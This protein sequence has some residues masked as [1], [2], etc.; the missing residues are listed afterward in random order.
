M[1]SRKRDASAIWMSVSVLAVMF[2]LAGAGAAQA[3]QCPAYDPA[4]PIVKCTGANTWC[5]GT[6]VASEPVCPND[7]KNQ[8]TKVDCGGCTCTCPDSF[9]MNCLGTNGYCQKTN[10]ACAPLNR[11]S[12]CNSDPGAPGYPDVTLNKCGSCLSGFTE[13]FGN[14]VSSTNPSC[15]PP[16]IWDPCN[17]KCIEKYV[18]SNPTPAQAPQ[19]VDIK[20][21]GNASI[22]TGDLFFSPGKAIRVDG[23][24]ATQL[25]IG[26]WGGGATSGNVRI[27]GSL[28]TDAGVSTVD[29]TPV[30]PKTVKTDSLCLTNGTICK[31]EW[32]VGLP[33]TALAGET[34][35][36]DGTAWV[37]SSFL[38]NTT[39][40]VGIGTTV[41]G[42]HLDVRS[43]SGE[44]MVNI[45]DRLGTLWT[46]V[47]MG[48]LTAGDEN[49]EK[50]FVGM[51]NA[52][53][54]FRIRR[55]GAADDVVVDTAGNVGIGQAV[56][57]QKLDVN[58]TAQVVGFKMP[59]GA[60]DTYILTSDADG[61]GT[62]QVRPIGLP[63][64]A[65]AGDTL[66]YNGTLWINNH[67]LYNDGSMIAIGN[68]SPGY[69]LDISSA[70]G[71]MV[72]RLNQDTTT[73][74]WTGLRLD[75]QR[76]E[77]WY[78]GMN[79]TDDKLLLRRGGATNDLVIDTTGKV[80]VGTAFPDA[81]FEVSFANANTAP[82]MYAS[83]LKITNTDPTN[84]NASS[85]LFAGSNGR[86]AGI[87]AIMTDHT[88][89][90][91]NSDLAFYTTKDNVLSEK[92]R[93]MDGGAVGIGVPDPGY[94]LDV[95]G[96]SGTAVLRVN[97]ASAGKLWTGV[98]LDRQRSEKWY[99][100]IN[101]ID[102]KLRFRRNG[103]T[104]DLVVDAGKVGVG[105]DTPSFTMDVAG[106]AQVTGFKMPT[107]AVDKY[108]LTSDPS[109]QASWQK[110]QFADECTGGKFDH[111]TAAS[112]DGSQG[113]YQSV[114]ALCGAGMH[115]CT[116]DEIL[117]TVQCAAASLPAAGSYSWIANGAPGFTSPAANDCAGWTSNAFNSYGDF[118]E[119]SGAAGGKGLATGCN[120]AYQIACCK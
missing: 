23:T 35:R 24:G 114:N 62:W 116:P 19:P 7:P 6:C 89:G 72:L 54:N 40:A 58:G 119:F 26:N 12:V 41:P 70:S 84:N 110:M 10:D 42:W 32:P 45:D 55:S 65:D 16:A 87:S 46:G 115:I 21:I 93:I 67:Q 94:P 3:K 27:F 8:L 108:V 63:A 82:L 28:F 77:K 66:R 59:T 109:G 64:V 101:D 33:T 17:N 60:Q 11:Q 98:R 95:N 34:L 85:L 57:A 90:S 1:A 88:V 31:S 2:F 100:G 113:G 76:A 99:I 97:Q 104:D 73:N 112:Y 74:L 9:P 44:A 15:P 52:S 75:R 43:N 29:A 81:P 92:M 25:N 79:S 80:G 38:F 14:C 120:A 30:A 36:F 51:N 107:G 105:T 96:G 103:S 47:R 68:T 22:S 111:L 4:H 86:V 118:W 13:C 39:T 117:K 83:S 48:R 61:V 106:T 71:T 69:P 49:K 78:I 56:P 102:E 50:W 18:L 5:G 53:D 91:A 20:V 37:A